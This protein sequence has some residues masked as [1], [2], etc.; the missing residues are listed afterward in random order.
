MPAVTLEKIRKRH[1]VSDTIKNENF[2]YSQRRHIYRAPVVNFY[3]LT[4]LL[5]PVKTM[6]SFIFMEI[7]ASTIQFFVM[8]IKM[9]LIVKRLQMTFLQKYI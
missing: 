7:Y 5:S 2:N 9:N 8:Q 6:V 1:F 3:S 4:K